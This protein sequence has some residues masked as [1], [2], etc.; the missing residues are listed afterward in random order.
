LKVENVFNLRIFKLSNFQ[1]ISLSIVNYQLSICNLNLV[2]DIG[3]SRIKAAVFNGGG[4]VERI[5]LGDSA[6]E[7]LGA[8]LNKYPETDSAIVCSTRGERHPAEDFLATHTNR[9]IRF[10][11]GIPTPLKNLYGTPETL[12]PDRLAAAVGAHALHPGKNL[13]VIDFGTALPID[14]VTAA[15]EYAGGNISPGVSMRFHALRDYTGR[16]P[17][18]EIQN[19]GVKEAVLS[20]K[21]TAEAIEA[22]VLNGIVFELEGYI[23]RIKGKF[24]DLIVI[25]TGGEAKFFDNKFKNTIFANYD[26]VFIGLNTIL[27][28]N[29]DKK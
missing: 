17:L 3:N 9:F 1:I 28:Y 7:E 12:G 4:I 29:A 13:L 24:G 23:E 15:G 6:T 5:I 16:L 14:T 10:A 18:I 21:S 25:L 11:N 19:E 2:L 20:G 8:V 27:D 22:G 26:L